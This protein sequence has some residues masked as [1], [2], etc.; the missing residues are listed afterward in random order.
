MKQLRNVFIAVTLAALSWSSAA[1]AAREKYN[2]DPVHSQSSF[3]IRHLFSK[4]HGR[5]N[6]T[7][8]A[9]LF[10]PKNLAGSSVEVTIPA[11]SI[12]TD[13]ERRDNDL[14]SANFFDVANHADITFKS[15]KVI[16]GKDSKFR[17]EGD[18]T[19][20]GVTKKAVLDAEFLGA[21]ATGM[22]GTR[23]GFEASTTINRLDYG[24]SWNKTLDQGG[25]VLGNDVSIELSVEAQ[26]EEAPA[27]APSPADKK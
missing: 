3:T 12:N 25:T 2:I 7:N 5:F 23:A 15:T 6:Q 22:M 24:V 20:R 10:D 26:K 14:R 11:S 8:G 13:N 17:V 21:G 1:F 16:P 18:L 9:I 27:A 19:I 4:V